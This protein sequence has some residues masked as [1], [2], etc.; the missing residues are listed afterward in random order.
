MAQGLSIDLQNVSSERAHCPSEG[1]HD[2]ITPCIE[3]L[4][5]RE[6]KQ[7]LNGKVYNQVK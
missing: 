3:T 1:R 7:R 6:V 4:Q 5:S 2:C